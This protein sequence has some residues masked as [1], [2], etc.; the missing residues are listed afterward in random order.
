MI[1]FFKA[2]EIIT[3]TIIQNGIIIIK[4][5]SSGTVDILII[6]SILPS[7]DWTIQR[8]KVNITHRLDMYLEV[9]KVSIR[10]IF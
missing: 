6:M 9:M 3:L 4:S 8:E 10:I 2:M 1:I 7:L 5:R